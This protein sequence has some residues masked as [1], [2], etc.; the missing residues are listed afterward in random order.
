MRSDR[1]ANIRR[2]DKGALVEER[3]D[4]LVR[5]FYHRAAAR[6]KVNCKKKLHR[7]RFGSSLRA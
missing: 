1:E 5:E 2:E 6:G 7:T 4:M 3:V